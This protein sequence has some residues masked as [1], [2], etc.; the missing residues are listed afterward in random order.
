[1]LR[2]L[3]GR[4]EIMTPTSEQAMT[5]AVARSATSRAQHLISQRT[6]DPK[7]PYVT[8]KDISEFGRMAE[9]ALARIAK[10]AQNAS[11]RKEAELLV[12]ELQSR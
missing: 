5:Q 12:S 7:M 10:I 2:V 6:R 4:M 9:P 8:P 11:V 1:M 3:V